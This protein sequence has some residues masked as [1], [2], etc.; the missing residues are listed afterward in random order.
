MF[1][2]VSEDTSAIVADVLVKMQEIHANSKQ[3]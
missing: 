2:N 3:H 1:S